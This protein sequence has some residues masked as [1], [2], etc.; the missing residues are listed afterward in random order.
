MRRMKSE[1]KKDFLE[2]AEDELDEREEKKRKLD[3]EI[4][5]NVFP[6]PDVGEEV[7]VTWGADKYQPVQFNVIETPSFTRTTKVRAGETA[8]D[9]MRRALSDCEKLAQEYFDKK[10]AMFARNHNRFRK[11]TE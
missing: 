1:P 4:G 9:A 6:T 2:E 10:L 5:P 7:T 3:S 11:T 8:T